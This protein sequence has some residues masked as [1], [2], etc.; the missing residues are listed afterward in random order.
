[1]EWKKL[2]FDV[3]S[4]SAINEQ[5]VY[6]KALS[7]LAS[8]VEIIFPSIQFSSHTILLQIDA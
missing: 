5:Y 8:A 7:A 3:V 4:C 1:M 2:T 6:T